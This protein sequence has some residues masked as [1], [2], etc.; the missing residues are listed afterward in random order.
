MSPQTQTE[1][2][3]HHQAAAPKA[4]P[5]RTKRKAAGKRRTKNP[6]T[7][8]QRLELVRGLEG[9]PDELVLTVGQWAV[10]NGFSDATATR[11]LSDPIPENRPDVVRMSTQRKG[12]TIGAN[13]AW[14]ARRS[15]PAAR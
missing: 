15:R 10:L 3:V 9:S 6:P 4:P 11:I 13:K 8:Q 2:H 14:Q 12:I 7:L 5:K 1:R